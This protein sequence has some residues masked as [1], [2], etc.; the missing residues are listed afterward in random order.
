MLETLIESKIYSYRHLKQSLIWI[1]CV[2]EIIQFRPYKPVSESACEFYVN[3]EVFFRIE[4]QPTGRAPP[5]WK[6]L[7]V[8]F[9]KNNWLHN[10]DKL[11]CNQHATFTICILFSILITTAIFRPKTL[12]RAGAAPPVLACTCVL[13]LLRNI[14]NVSVISTVLNSKKMAIQTIIYNYST[15]DG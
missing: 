13:L 5:V 11:Y 15:H 2:T 8:Y 6:C 10:T 14:C 7:R 12:Y 9:W 1:I 3:S 4:R